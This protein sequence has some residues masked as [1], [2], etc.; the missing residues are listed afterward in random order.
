MPPDL[1][2]RLR[3]ASVVFLL[4]HPVD[5]QSV[6]AASLVRNGIVPDDW[7]VANEVNLAGVLAQTVFR[8]GVNV[9]AEGN[10]CIFQQNVNGA[11]REEYD[12]HQA[13]ANYADASRV[14]S[15]QAVGL[16]W[17]LEPD[18]EQAGRWLIGKFTGNSA[19]APGFQPVS[20]KVARRQGA[21]ICNLTFNLEQ[22]SVVL[23]CNYHVELG[24]SRAID[25]IKMWQHYQTN[26][27]E[28][29]LPTITR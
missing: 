5:S 20:V 25:V 21:A 22:D 18:V 16:N 13:A 19:F 3:H 14:I 15:Y 6:N 27:Q 28:D 24:G 10:R 9:R 17:M 4:P 29:I 7:Q 11:F 26:L 2:F 1:N 8:N 12:A 23:D